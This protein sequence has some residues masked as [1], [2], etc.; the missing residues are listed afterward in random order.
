MSEGLRGRDTAS[1]VAA[2]PSCSEE[3]RV[4]NDFLGMRGKTGLDGPDEY[5]SWPLA[6]YLGIMPY[7]FHGVDH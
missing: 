3:S 4:G 7:P 5:E 2:Q 6:S 1:R